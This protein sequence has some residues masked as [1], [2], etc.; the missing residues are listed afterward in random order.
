MTWYIS[1]EQKDNNK[2]AFIWGV[3][4]EL[5]KKAQNILDVALSRVNVVWQT[6]ITEENTEAKSKGFYYN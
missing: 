1:T 3:C 5:L 2:T 4:L 6:Y